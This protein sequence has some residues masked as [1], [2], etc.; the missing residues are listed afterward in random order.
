M[1]V[2]MQSCLV[3]IIKFDILKFGYYKAV[4]LKQKKHMFIYLS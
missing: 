2:E 4:G 1:W 3:R